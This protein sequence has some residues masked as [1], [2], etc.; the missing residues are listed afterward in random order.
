[1]Q[2]SSEV[3]VSTVDVLRQWSDTAIAQFYISRQ[4][5]QI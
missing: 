2:S 4:P 5:Y 1:M 3:E